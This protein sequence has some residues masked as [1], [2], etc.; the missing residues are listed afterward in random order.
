MIYILTTLQM[1]DGIV[2]EPTYSVILDLERNN[3]GKSSMIKEYDRRKNF[4]DFALR[5]SNAE[6]T[7][8]PNL[9]ST[10]QRRLY[11]RNTI[12][13][14]HTIRL[15]NKP[16]EAIAK[17]D[18]LCSS[19]FNFFRGTA[20][21]YYRDQAGSDSHLPIVF[22]IGDVHP[23]NFGVMPN[24]NNV[25]FFGVNDFDEAYFAPFSFDV[26]RGATG[27]YIV[28]KEQGFNKKQRKKVVKRFVRGYI[29]GLTSFAKDDRERW[30]QYRLDNS[31]G[32]IKKLLKKA[33]QDRVNFLKDIIDIKTERF[34]ISDKIVPYTEQLKKF[35]ILVT[36]YVKDNDITVNSNINDYFKVKDVAI[37]K[38]SGTAS[39]G[40]DRFWV[41]VNG[42][43]ERI[44][45]NIV[46]EIKQA[47]HSA[48]TG[49]VGRSS[50]QNE[51]NKAKHIVE[52]HNIHLAGGDKFYGYAKH[53][54]KSYL[55]R[56]RSPFKKEINV[57][58][59]GESRMIEYAHICGQT[60]VQ[61]HARSDEDTG[62]TDDN[63]EKTILES[64]DVDL[65]INDI[66]RF[67]IE[68]TSRI[69]K[70]FKLFQ[71]DHKLGAFG[72]RH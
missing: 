31:P 41:L 11:L 56:E 8:P 6:I 32:L 68:A 30:H 58:D 55:I 62:V 27:F 15:R 25:P 47:R 4:E 16:E 17:F 2:S 59:L 18:K 14:D 46:L 36:K 20:L 54:G 49:L 60:L 72:F 67:A 45:D 24:E 71:K 22:T 29:S 38:G 42:P 28:C 10:E 39:L 19:L 57:S 7:T 65:F 9:L 13:E 50:V 64:I 66:G 69:S 53:E 5:Q 3:T 40:L 52:A 33:N 70:D 61:T 26:K 12:R 1:V 63:S 48:L 44:T 21:L 51:T 35:Q 37:K 34:R 43:S 23:E